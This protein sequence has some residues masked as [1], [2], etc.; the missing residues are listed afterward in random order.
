MKDTSF[1]NAFDQLF[2]IEIDQENFQ[3]LIYARN[4]LY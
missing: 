3:I 4:A 1:I 2:G